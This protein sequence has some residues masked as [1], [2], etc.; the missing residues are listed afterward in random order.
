MNWHLGMRNFALVGKD[1]DWCV[2]G[3]SGEVVRTKIGPDHPIS[4]CSLATDVQ[5]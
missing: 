5:S 4:L 2:V 3:V 1:I